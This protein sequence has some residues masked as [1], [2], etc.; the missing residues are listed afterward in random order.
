MTEGNTGTVNA[1]FTVTLSAASGQTVTVNYATANG[2]RHGARDY[3]AASRHADLR[4]GRDTPDD[5]RAGR[6][7]RARRGERDVQR[8]PERADQRDDRRR[9][10]RRHHHRQRH[11]A[12]AG[13]QQ[14]DRDRRERRHEELVFTVTLSAASG[15][16][17]TVNYATANGTANSTFLIGDYVA[18][19]GSLT[20]NPGT[21]TQSITVSVRGNTTVEPNETFSVN[22]SNGVNVTIADAQGIGTILNDD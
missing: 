13:H 18:T 11:D 20:F 19:S 12:V 3:T 7:R 9:P 21:T 2:T 17:V 22:L 15:Q 4:A 1:V 5:H 10:G 14:R 16:A 6:R 8:Q